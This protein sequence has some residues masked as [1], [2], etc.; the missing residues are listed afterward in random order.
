MKKI[1]AVKADRISSSYSDPQDM[2]GI[3]KH[4]K[5][6]AKLGFSNTNIYLYIDEEKAS[7]IRRKLESL[8]F[9]VC[10]LEKESSFELHLTW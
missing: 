9:E 7:N 3:M 6:M 8:G 4:I 2:K 5:D 1:D 10:M